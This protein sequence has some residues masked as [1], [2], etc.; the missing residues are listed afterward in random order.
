MKILLI[1][2]AMPEDSPYVNYYQKILKEKDGVEFDIIAWNRYNSSIPKSNRHIIVYSKTS[3]NS[4]IKKTAQY[5]GYRKFILKQAKRNKYDG[6]IVFTVAMALLLARFLFKSYKNRYII[7]I[8]DYSPLVRFGLAKQKLHKLLLLSYANVI[9]SP[10]FRFWLPPIKDNCLISHNTDTILLKEVSPAKVS[11]KPLKVLTIGALR[12]PESNLRLIQALEN[13]P[14]FFMQFSGKGKATATINGY[15]YSNN[16]N[17]AI[18][19]GKYEKIDEDRIVSDS[20]MINILLPHNMV[21]DYLMSNRFYLSVIYGKPMIVNS[22]CTQSYYVSKYNLGVVINDNEDI[23]EKI[24]K[25]CDVFD[26]QNYNSGRSAFMETVKKDNYEFN[27]AIEN[28][29]TTI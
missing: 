3:G 2:G 6:V 27:K 21:S 26:L 13:N 5:I 28:F 12:D 4:R 7:D 29:I 22:D 17:N 9:S 20:D 15:I 24:L 18:V 25:Y 10:G 19:T 1:L 8:R 16:V 23:A 14:R 11:N